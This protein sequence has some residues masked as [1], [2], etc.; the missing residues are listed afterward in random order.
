MQEQQKSASGEIGARWR[1][2]INVT[3]MSQSHECRQGRE[4][5]D[6]PVAKI[7]RLLIEQLIT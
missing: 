7:V 6:F 1:A 3:I 2:N 5:F 4:G